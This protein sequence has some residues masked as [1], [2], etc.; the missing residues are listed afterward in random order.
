MSLMQIYDGGTELI[1]RAR[2]GDPVAFG[3][4]IEPHRVGLVAYARCLCGDFSSAEDVVQDSLLIAYRNI[5]RL[6]PE[7]DFRTWVKAIVRRQALASGRSRN[8]FGPLLTEHME[9]AFEIEDDHLE[10][11]R[12]A[13]RRCLGDLPPRM[14]HVIDAFY[15][16]G[17]SVGH[18]SDRLTTPTG[19]VKT[20]LHRARSA[21]RDC[22]ERRLRVTRGGA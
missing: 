6:F 16:G 17:E 15:S 22:I 19:T 14:R 3:E 20:L 13:L 5:E 21:L 4:L 2:K 9:A 1:E 7:A 10:M 11:E 12:L 8:R 18:I